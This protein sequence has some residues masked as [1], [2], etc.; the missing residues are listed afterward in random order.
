MPVARRRTPLDLFVGGERPRCGVRQTSNRG[1]PAGP[2]RLLT[3]TYLYLLSAD[4]RLLEKKQM[5][6]APWNRSFG[7]EANGVFQVGVWDLKGDGQ[8]EI[9]VTL[10]NSEVQAFAADW[11][12]LWESKDSALRGTKQLSFVDLDGDG[13]PQTI[14]L[15]DKYGYCVGLDTDGHEVYRGRSSIGDVV[16][17]VAPVDGGKGRRIVTASSGAI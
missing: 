10:G 5:H 12:P 13:R 16:F 8:N 4:G 17:A 6:G 11:K 14:L 7:D 2:G 3:S 1:E 15:G 9:V